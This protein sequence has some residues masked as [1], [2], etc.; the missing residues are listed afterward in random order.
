MRVYSG[1]H[2]LLGREWMGGHKIGGRRTTWCGPSKRKCCEGSNS[3]DSFFSQAV[4][5]EECEVRW[6]VLLELR[7]GGVVV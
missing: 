6:A 4:L 1:V 2:E 3:G 5:W 7:A